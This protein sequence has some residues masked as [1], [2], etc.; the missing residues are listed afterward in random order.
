MEWCAKD[1][2]F[3]P[4]SQFTTDQATG[5][6]MHQKSADQPPH[7]SGDRRPPVDEPPMTIDEP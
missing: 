7:P 4:E 3:Y 5:L 2:D 6:R 1:R